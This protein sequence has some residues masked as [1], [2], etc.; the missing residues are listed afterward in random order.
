MN[1][2]YIEPHKLAYKEIN[3]DQNKFLNKIP[4][5]NFF[6]LQTNINKIGNKNK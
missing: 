6:P 3:P 1:P 4:K 2:K 5:K